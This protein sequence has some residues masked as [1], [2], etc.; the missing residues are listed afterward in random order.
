MTSN[1]YWRD[2]LI[3]YGE[4]RNRKSTECSAQLPSMELTNMSKT[5]MLELTPR[6]LFCCLVPYM[7]NLYKGVVKNLH[8]LWRYWGGRAGREREPVSI[9]LWITKTQDCH[10]VLIWASP[11]WVGSVKG[12]VTDYNG[13]WCIQWY[14][15]IN[16]NSQI[17]SPI[18]RKLKLGKLS[19]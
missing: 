5:G 2:W 3:L 16:T 13:C 7:F 6:F 4:S 9:A 14:K 18:E 8:I 19:I 1:I 11:F 12:K 17:R 15:F 10:L